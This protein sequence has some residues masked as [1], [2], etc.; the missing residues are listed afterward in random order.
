MAQTNQR[1]LVE[2]AQ[3]LASFEEIITLLRRQIR[4]LE[5]KIAGDLL[6]GDPLW[7]VLDETF[8]SIKGVADRTV[9]RGQAELPEIGTLSNK[10]VAG[11]EPA[12]L[13]IAR[14]SGKRKGKRSGS[15]EAE[16]A[17]DPSSSWS[18]A[19]CAATIGTSPKSTNG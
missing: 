19:S 5:K 13:P 3:V 11:A 9:A 16:R 6:A 4:G 2:E 8:R 17:C 12:W 10:A 7:R 18:P 15:A 1:R 14:D